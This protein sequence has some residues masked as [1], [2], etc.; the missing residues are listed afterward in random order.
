M[1]NSFVTRVGSLEAYICP[2]RTFH[3]GKGRLASRR[4]PLHTGLRRFIKIDPSWGGVIWSLYGFEMLN[5]V[6]LILS[7]Q[8]TKH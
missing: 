7:S 5:L 3:T 8:T 1:S 2:G 4:S 6:S